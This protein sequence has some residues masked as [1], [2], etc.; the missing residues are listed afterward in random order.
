MTHAS[1]GC[2]AFG[3]ISMLP[4]TTPIGSEPW[5]ATEEIAH[6]DTEVG[7]PGYYTVRFPATGVV[8]ELT[9]TTHTGVGRFTYP[10]NGQPRSVLCEFRC[11]AWG[12]LRR[13]HPDRRR[14]HHDHWIGDQRRLLRQG[15]RLHG[16]LRDE[17]QPAVHV[18][19]HLGRLLGLRRHPQRVFELHRV[20]R[21]IRGVPGGLAGRGAALRSPMSAS[22]E[23]E[24]TSPPRAKASFD[25]VRAAAA[26][27]WNGKLSRISIASA[28]DGDTKTFYTALY[29]SLLN[30]N[31]FNDVDGRYIGFDGDVHTLPAGH[32]QYTNFSDWDT[33]R[34][35]GLRCT[36]CCSRSRPAT[37]PSRW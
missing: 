3:D 37:W 22:T 31:T 20:Q 25:D 16:V 34:G 5:D 29:H 2:A 24:P 13:E 19:R 8:A 28:D 32:T 18:L 12:Y 15:Q 17:V 10:D 6:D 27:E 26:R 11:V 23:R 30:P 9:A 35:L 21:G 1:V 4:T 36:D 33:Y 14:Q 7:V